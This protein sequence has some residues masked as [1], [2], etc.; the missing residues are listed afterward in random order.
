MQQRAAHGEEAHP[1]PAV[2]PPFSVRDKVG[3][4]SAF[5][6]K[7]VSQRFHV[8]QAA[9]FGA[10]IAVATQCDMVAVDGYDT[11]QDIFV[12]RDLCKHRI[13]DTWLVTTTQQ[14]LVALMTEK[15]AHAVA[16]QRDGDGLA[17]LYVSYHFRKE[18]LVWH[19]D[20]C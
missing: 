6:Q 2:H 11:M 3:S 8:R 13:A 12:W 18:K 10:K 20:V 1:Q 9:V 7:A 19:A 5:A 15:G 16:L 14:R 4:C 17:H